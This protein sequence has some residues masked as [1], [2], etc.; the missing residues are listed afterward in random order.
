MAWRN[1][2]V[3]HLRNI[4][5]KL[6]EN[7]PWRNLK[8]GHLRNISTKLF[9]NQPW[10]NLKMGHLRNISTKLFENQPNIFVG[11]DFLSFHYSHIRQ[12]SPAPLAAMFFDQ[13]TWLEG[14]WRKISTKLFENLPTSLGEEEFWSFF[15]FVAMETRIL[16]GSQ[17]FE[18]NLVRSLRGCFLWSF[19]PIDPLV[20]EEKKLTHDKC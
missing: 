19:F 17:K 6:F 18:G 2:K 16:H 15:H 20:T 1:L 3:G 4:S 9:E 14:I 11:D 10:R 12:N 13:S 8:V 5:T 7:R